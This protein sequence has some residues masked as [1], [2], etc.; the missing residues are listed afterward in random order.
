MHFFRGGGGKGSGEAGA[1]TLGLNKK[2][3]F[4]NSRR[5]EASASSCNNSREQA[6]S[7]SVGLCTQMIDLI[8]GL[9]PSTKRVI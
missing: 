5:L 3:G 7:K 2:S 6:V 1:T 9:K 4:L 8:S